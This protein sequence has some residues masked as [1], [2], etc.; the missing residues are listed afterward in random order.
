MNF[1]LLRRLLVALTFISISS[2]SFART[3]YVIGIP[4]W[5]MRE[6]ESYGYI[7][8]SATYK[9][10]LKNPGGELVNKEYT[11]TLSSQGLYY[12]IGTYFPITRLGRV[13]T[14]ALSINQATHILEWESVKGGVMD[15]S[16]FN[17]GGTTM[18]ATLPIGADFMFGSDAIERKNP[19]LCATLGAGLSPMYAMTMIEDNEGGQFTVRPYV[20]AEAGIYLGI[21][22]KLRVMCN[23]GNINYVDSKNSFLKMGDNMTSNFTFKGN[24]SV[25]VSLVLLP[26]SYM[27]EKTGWWN[28]TY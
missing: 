21:C 4:P 28:D 19:R 20:K 9:G 8:G 14:L 5:M 3:V 26:F 24:S 12:G 7:M 25:S 27:W 11:Q 6:N 15:A 23:F 22:M 10:Q 2:V 17:F 1:V 16:G 13:S 18:E